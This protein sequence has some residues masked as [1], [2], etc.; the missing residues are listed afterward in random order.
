MTRTVAAGVAK[1][2][3]G[4]PDLFL[5]RDGEPRADRERRERAA[6]SL[7]GECPVRGDCLE[8]ALDG[9]EVGAVW[10]GL[11]DQERRELGRELRRKQLAGARR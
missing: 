4:K 8:V 5:E 9:K 1:P 6:K 3:A 2:C 11:N 10:G 7:C